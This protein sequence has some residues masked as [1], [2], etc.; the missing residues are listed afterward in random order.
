MSDIEKNYPRRLIR[1]NISIYNNNRVR[2][3]EDEI[4]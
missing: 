1:D 3:F 2:Y 4:P